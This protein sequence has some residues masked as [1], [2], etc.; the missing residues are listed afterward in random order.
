MLLDR[1]SLYSKHNSI[2]NAHPVQGSYQGHIKKY[3][4]AR[5]D[6]GVYVREANNAKCKQHI[7]KDTL[8]WTKKEAPT[9]PNKAEANAAGF[10]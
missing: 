8:E 1:H 5:G 9:R 3:K 10:R 7:P 2:K 6:L 4:K